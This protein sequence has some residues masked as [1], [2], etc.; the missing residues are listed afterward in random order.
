MHM[1]TRIC[2]VFVVV[3]GGGGGGGGSGGSGAIGVGLFSHGVLVV[4]HPYFENPSFNS[5]FIAEI[6]NQIFVSLLHFP[7]NSFR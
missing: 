6:S 7:S 5:D 3:D 2:S 1:Q 4:M